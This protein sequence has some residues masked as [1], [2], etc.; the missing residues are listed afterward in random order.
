MNCC[1]IECSFRSQYRASG[2]TLIELM[3]VVAIVGIL[4][5]I[6]YPSYTAYVR[7][8]QCEEAKGVLLNAANA[9]ERYRA[10]KRSYSGTRAGADYPDQ[11]PVDGSAVY[12][13]RRGDDNAAATFTLRAESTGRDTISVT[14]VGVKTN[15]SCS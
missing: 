1:E 15:W 7:R 9:L 3:V 12:T 8:A 13:I 11:S 4:A 2:F 6:A 10:R 5:S 14:N